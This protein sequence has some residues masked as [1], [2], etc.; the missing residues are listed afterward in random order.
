MIFFLL[1]LSFVFSDGYAP[2]LSMSLRN[3]FLTVKEDTTIAPGPGSYNPRLYETVSG[4]S[5]LAN[6]SIR[7]HNR[8]QDTPG[9][10]TYTLS[11]TSDWLKE[12]GNKEN[13]SAP[14]ERTVIYSDLALNSEIFNLLAFSFFFLYHKFLELR[15]FLD[16]NF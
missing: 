13:S 4:G 5:A 1:F 15:L 8:V 3:S 11:K 6:Q 16:L 12:K 14:R 7:F 10:G 2:F 9:P